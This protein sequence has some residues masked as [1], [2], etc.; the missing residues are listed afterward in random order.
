MSILYTI[1]NILDKKKKRQFFVIFFLM[2]IGSI[3]EILSIGMILPVLAFISQDPTNLDTN[4]LTSFTKHISNFSVSDLLKYSIVIF[5]AIYVLR[6][7]FL[8]FL[9]WIQNNYIYA[10]S[11]AVSGLVIA[12]FRGTSNLEMTD[13]SRILEYLKGSVI[14]LNLIWFLSPGRLNSKADYYSRSVGIS[15]IQLGRKLPDQL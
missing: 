2:L 10:T 6:T 1:W 12:L 4:Y 7:I 13:S 8:F 11:T 14:L 5:C 15:L 9:A 3:L